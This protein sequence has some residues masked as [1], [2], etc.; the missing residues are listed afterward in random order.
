[1]VL[2]GGQ[3]AVSC[4]VHDHQHARFFP[5][6]EGLKEHVAVGFDGEFNERL[7]LVP[8]ARHD[9]AFPAGEHVPFHHPR[10]TGKGI[11]GS[12][13]IGRFVQSQVSSRRHACCLHGLFGME[14]GTLQ[15]SEGRHGTK[16]GHTGLSARIG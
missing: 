2:T 6:E 10:V 4:P 13:D 16:T 8:V 5:R 9:H 15:V 14:F 1:M 11:Q 12:L 3:R 7:R